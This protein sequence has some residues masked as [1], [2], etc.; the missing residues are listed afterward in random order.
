MKTCEHCLNY[1]AETAVEYDAIVQSPDGEPCPC[2]AA[3]CGHRLCLELDDAAPC[4]RCDQCR[5]C[6]PC[7]CEACGAALH[8][9]DDCVSCLDP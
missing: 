1:R 9:D 3:D 2:I 5:A 6:C 4:P 7:A 8:A